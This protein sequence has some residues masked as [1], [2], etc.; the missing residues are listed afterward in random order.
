MKKV[1]PN[2]ID[3]IQ[4]TLLSG[5]SLLQS[6]LVA[7]EVVEEA[8]R[9][10]KSCLIFKINFEKA[11]HLVRWSFLFYMLQ[12]LGFNEKKISWIRVYLES[13]FVSILVNGSPTSEF[14]ISKGLR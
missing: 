9:K 3:R 11:Y 2:V 10:K 8:R 6:A 12:R 4:S 13:S 1:Q 7:S 14:K 5:R